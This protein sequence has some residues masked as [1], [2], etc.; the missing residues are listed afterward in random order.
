MAS[1]YIERQMMED[2]RGEQ[3]LRMDQGQAYRMEEQK[4][5]EGLRMSAQKQMSDRR[6]YMRNPMVNRRTNQMA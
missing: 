1:T 6:M 3:I 4:R 5:M 2:S